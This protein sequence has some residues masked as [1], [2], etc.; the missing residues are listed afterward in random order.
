M[1]RVMPGLDIAALAAAEGPLG[2]A[3][4]AYEQGDHEEAARLV[5][6]LAAQGEVP[7]QVFLALMYHN[8]DGVAKDHARES[9]WFRAAARQGDAGAEYQY[10]VNLT[11]GHGVAADFAEAIKTGGWDVV[12]LD[13]PRSG[14]KAIVGALA[15]CAAK[16]IVYV[17]C[18]PAT[19]ARDAHSLAQAG[20]KIGRCVVVDMFPNTSHIEAVCEFARD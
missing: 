18:D 6:P 15:T 10:A 5:A 7:A 3:V 8:G 4:E 17:S 2:A 19:L 11:G 16:K 9:E 13:P 12:L 1:A 20:W 14:A